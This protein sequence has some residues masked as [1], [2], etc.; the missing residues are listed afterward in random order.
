MRACFMSLNHFHLGGRTKVLPSDFIVEEVWNDRV[1]KIGYSLLN[2][3]KDKL[4][5]AH[6]E[7]KDYLHFTLVKRNWDTVRALKY[8]GKKTHVSLK[9]FG[10]SGM[11]DKRA[12]TAQRVSL[13]RGSAKAMVHLKLHDMI[14]KDFEYADE[15][16]TLGN[17]M[18]N[19]FTITIRDIPKNKKQIVEILNCFEEVATSRGAPNYFGPQRLCGGNADVGR[20]IKDGNL[21]LAVELILKK[22]QPYLKEGD[23]NSIPRALWY[24]KMMLRHLEKYP[25]DHAGALRK[26]PKRIR[27]LYTHAYQS[28]IFNEK[29]GQTLL[30]SNVPKTIPVQGF[31]TPKMPELST[32]PFERNSFLVAKD[33]RILR[34]RDGLAKFSFTLNKGEYASTLLSYLFP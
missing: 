7:K 29:L 6:K 3:F 32:T 27:R 33:F 4:M 22:I 24:E 8:I 23:I 10:I 1:C 28:H 17:A 11:K 25:N 14:V 34:V 30:S 20:A 26:I 15:R 5:I 13:W 2:R 18:G 16:I 12:I 9:R 19:R 21:K 31:K